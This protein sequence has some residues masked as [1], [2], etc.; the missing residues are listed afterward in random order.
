MH[1]FWAMEE[2][3]A[4]MHEMQNLIENTAMMT[5]L[6]FVTALG[7]GKFSLDNRC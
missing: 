1:N 2:G 7:T 4:R 3:V 5:G 6:L